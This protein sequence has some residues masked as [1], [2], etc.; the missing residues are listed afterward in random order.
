M[1]DSRSW[2]VAAAAA[3]VHTIQTTCYQMTPTVLMPM[4]LGEFGASVLRA[5]SV[6]AIGRMS[7]VVALPFGGALVDRCGPTPCVLAGVAVL[8]VSA[9]LFTRMQSMTEFSVLQVLN[10]GAMACAG[11]PVYAVL[12]CR[13]FR[14][15][16]GAALGMVLAGFSLAGA[17]APLLLGGMATHWSWRAAA[18][19]VA[20]ALLMVALP[21]T[22]WLHRVASSRMRTE[23]M[24]GEDIAATTTT[25]DVGGDGAERRSRG[26]PEEKGVK[27]RTVSTDGDLPTAASTDRNGAMLTSAADADRRPAP[28]TATLATA[29]LVSPFRTMTFALLAPS[30]FLLQYAFG[31][32]SEHF[33]I[34]LSVDG[35]IRLHAASV[36][37][38]V[39]YFCAF[40]AKLVGGYLGDRFNRAR[41][42]AVA[43][44]LAALG[45]SLL[46]VPLT[47]PL[48]SSTTSTTTASSHARLARVALLGFSS[49]FGFG[50]GSV[51]NCNYALVPQLLGTYQLGLVQSALYAVGLCGNAAGALL[52]GWLRTRL[53]SYESAFAVAVAAVVI[54]FFFVYALARWYRAPSASPLAPQPMLVSSAS[55]P[56]GLQRSPRRSVSVF[57]DALESGSDESVDVEETRGE[58]SPKEERDA[59]A[60]WR[61]MYEFEEHHVPRSLSS[62]YLS[63]RGGGASRSPRRSGEG[64]CGR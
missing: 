12:L 58:E 56:A 8:T 52:T 55:A 11:V 61:S 51:F 10:A 40:A 23:D 6:I 13:F 26:A 42:A 20:G 30:Y 41:I 37:L 25:T 57:F 18:R 46:F 59:L 53:F 34:W 36:Y 31:S 54:N 16:L 19:V 35:G 29:P 33:L 3:T 27:T 28:D 1:D 62:H 15:H 14:V 45:A 5:S 22:V 4:I 2:K 21:V 48:S 24:L 39:L 9:V 43:A 47:W 49:L 32:F 17:I 60:F 63:G 50:Y 7:F 64:Q 38:S 44:A